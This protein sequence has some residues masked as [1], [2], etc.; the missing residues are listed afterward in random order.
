MADFTKLSFLVFLIVLWVVNCVSED[1]EESNLYA[2]QGKVVVQKAPDS[3][4]IAQSR[5]VLDGGKYSG[6][7]RKDGGFVINRVP[8]G[9]YVVEV[10]TP[11]YSFEPVRVDVTKSGKIRARKINWLKMSSVE[12]IPYPLKFTTEAP[13]KFFQKRESWSLLDMVKNNPMV[14][15]Q[16]H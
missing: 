3:S 11:N 13:A 12:T 2:I 9:T 5:V 10:Y 16:R 8:S 1:V 7:L 14:R 15:V 4:W 6:Y